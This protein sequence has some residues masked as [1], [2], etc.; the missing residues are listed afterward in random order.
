MPKLSTV[1]SAFPTAVSC[2]SAAVLLGAATLVSASPYDKA[3]DGAKAAIGTV[4]TPAEQR[5]ADAPDGVDAMVTGPVSADFKQ[6]QAS[7]GCAIAKW[8]NVPLVCYPD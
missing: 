8:P 7:A 6:R 1:R 2:V 5:Y 4:A 3:V